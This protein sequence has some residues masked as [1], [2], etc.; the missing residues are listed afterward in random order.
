MTMR[1]LSHQEIVEVYASRPAAR[2]AMTG[3]AGEYFVAA[4][5]SLRGWL[6][7]AAYAQHLEWLSKS[8]RDGK[9][10]KDTKKRVMIP[11]EFS[12]YEERWDLLKS[13]ADEAPLL[14]GA[15]YAECVSEFGLPKDH[16]GW[17]LP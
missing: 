2:T 6:P 7:G 4:E 12:G 5:L 3:A 10:R 14:I 16:P 17:P 15:W 9:P 1:G 13:P 11:S 8:R